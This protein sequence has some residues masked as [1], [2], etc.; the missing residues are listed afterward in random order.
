MVLRAGK[1]K[2]WNSVYVSNRKIQIGFIHWYLIF[3]IKEFLQNVKQYK[4]NRIYIYKNYKS[5]SFEPEKNK[6]DLQTTQKVAI[7]ESFII[8][9]CKLEI[10]EA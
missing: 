10:Y 9:L 5:R 1:Y 3:F 6:N 2:Q 4:T 8:N 7:S